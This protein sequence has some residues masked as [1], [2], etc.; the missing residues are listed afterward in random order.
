MV[1][2]K[3]RYI[4]FRINLKDQPVVS[5]TDI[6]YT[7]KLLISQFFGINGSAII[8]PS[9]SIKYYDP[10]SAIG[11]LRCPRNEYRKV[12]CALSFLTCICNSK[13]KNVNSILSG[14]SISILYISGTI[15]KCQN[16]AIKHFSK[17]I[18]LSSHKRAK[19][20]K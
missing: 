5:Q 7:I 11:I 14:C 2:F 3:N 6:F 16:R 12:W 8:L 20:S 17:E 4:L 18:S 10:K 19:T 13:I 15:R 9:L 1:R